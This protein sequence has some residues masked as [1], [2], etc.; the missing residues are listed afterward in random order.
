MEA[1]KSRI[2][3]KVGTS[4]LTHE[5]GKLNFR[6]F[7][8]L[9]RVL[10]DIH[11]LGNE[12]ILVSSGAIAVGACKLLMSERPRELSLK[13][14]AAAVG[15]C[16][17]MHLYDK[18][19]GEYGKTVAQIL[20]TGDDVDSPEIKQSLINTFNSLLSLGIVPVVNE[21]DSVSSA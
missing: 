20:L 10:S 9:A 14:A 7:D 5:G 8:S 17:L 11:N 13:Q 1:S 16:E 6:S 2:V 12:V 21:N 4:T 18:F 3:V 15:Q 19:F